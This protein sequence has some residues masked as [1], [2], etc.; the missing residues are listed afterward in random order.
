MA[1]TTPL[2]EVLLNRETQGVQNTAVE[3]HKSP[4]PA[5]R[6]VP[7]PKPPKPP[8]RP[9]APIFPVRPPR[10]NGGR[11]GPHKAF[12]GLIR[13]EIR[14][15][16][17]FLGGKAAPQAVRVERLARSRQDGQSAE[18]GGKGSQLG[19]SGGKGIR[20]EGTSPEGSRRDMATILCLSFCHSF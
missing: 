2:T 19:A 10:A 17:L 6:N 16:E 3:R 9:F 7:G 11:D 20:V 5:P 15:C 8:P 4:A 1:R 12:S 13:D 18:R 14:P